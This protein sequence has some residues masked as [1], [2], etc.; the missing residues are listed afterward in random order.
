MVCGISRASG[1]LWMICSGQEDESRYATAETREARKSRG[2]RMGAVASYL[3]TVA[4]PEVP[5]LDAWNSRVLEGRL[6]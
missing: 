2:A 3:V 4:K 1:L 5:V 6:N